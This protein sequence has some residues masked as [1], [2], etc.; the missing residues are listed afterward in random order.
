ML[1][2]ESVN[3]CLYVR[4]LY[5][6]WN[7][8]EGPIAFI[9]FFK[10]LA[11]SKKVKTPLLKRFFTD[12]IQVWQLTLV[13]FHRTRGERCGIGLRDRAEL[14]H[15]AVGTLLTLPSFSVLCP[16]IS[17]INI[18]GSAVSGS[19][20]QDYITSLSSLLHFH[21]LLWLLLI[22]LDTDHIIAWVS[23]SHWLCL[24][25]RP[26]VGSHWKQLG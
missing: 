17:N 24:F 11:D 23:I 9:S 12:A 1:Q 15:R 8:E 25:P 5:I 21:T 26:G 19:W 6:F 13:H 3:L 4:C 20:F 16:R 14:G 2:R 18:L 7:L 22:I 10:G